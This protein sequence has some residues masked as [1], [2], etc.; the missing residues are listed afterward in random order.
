MGG[1]SSSGAGAAG[2]GGVAATAGAGGAASLA[3]DAQLVPTQGNSVT[4]S[5][6]FSQNGAEVELTI[7]LASCSAGPHALHLHANAAC[8]DNGNAAGGH[9]SPQGEGMGDVVC[10]ADG[11]AQVSFKAQAGL[12]SIGGAAATDLLQHAL[13]LH[14]ASGPDP[15]GRIACGI[16]LK[17]P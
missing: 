2:A 5:A 14:A 7:S 9:W 4:G 12:W 13:I 10:G 6:H 1:A 16:P 15:G 11:A 17:A 3:A 8:G